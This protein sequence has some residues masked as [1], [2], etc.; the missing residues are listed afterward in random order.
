MPDSLFIKFWNIVVML[1]LFY[2]VTYVPIQVCFIE[3]DVTGAVGVLN[4][5][6]DY[7]FV[8]DIFVSFTTAYDDPETALPVTNSKK[9][10]INYL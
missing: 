7:L 10:A 4:L 9:I 5:I 2:V 8:I 1:L 6:I 3:G